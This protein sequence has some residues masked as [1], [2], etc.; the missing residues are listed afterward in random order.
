VPNDPLM[1]GARA[2]H[3]LGLAA[4]LGGGLYGHL[5][6]HRAV[7]KVADHTERGKVVNAAWMAYNPVNVAALGAA[8]AG[9]LGSRG[10]ETR[11]DKLT[12][13]EQALATAKDALMATAVVTGVATGIT[14]TRLAR[15]A[16]DG[17][18][19][20]E[21]GDTPAPETPEKASKLVRQVSA[22]GKVNIVA[23]VALVALNGV[24]AQLDHSRPPLR[25]ALFR[26]NA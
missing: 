18:T 17:A 16:P 6:M 4:W 23:G 3:D 26:R 5:A 19:P 24:I 21:D 11:P 22:L 12:G 20:M 1:L 25:R 8:A 14:G 10:T 9:W 13:T 7:A 2:A 15:Q